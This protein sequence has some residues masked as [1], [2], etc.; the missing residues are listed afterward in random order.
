MIISVLC[1]ATK[2]AGFAKKGAEFAGK[3]AEFAKKGA[4]FAGKGRGKW[5][6]IW[7]GAWQWAIYG[8]GKSIYGAIIGPFYYQ[9]II[10]FSLIAYSRLFQ[11]YKTSDG[12]GL[13]GRS[14]ARAGGTRNNRFR[15]RDC[16]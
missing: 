15:N 16:R 10:S 9:L 3:W 7:R 4:G 13:R 14:G 5:R 1:D 2:G 6:I 11:M 8:D 12:L